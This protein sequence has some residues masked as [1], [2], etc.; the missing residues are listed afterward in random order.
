MGGIDRERREGGR[1]GGIG[2]C[3]EEKGEVKE[4]VS[5]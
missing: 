2:G 1:E 4:E 5:P 3:R